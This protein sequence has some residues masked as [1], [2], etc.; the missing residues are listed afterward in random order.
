MLKN[1]LSTLAISLVLAFT[2]LSV[3]FSFSQAI[4]AGILQDY[5]S[6]GTMLILAGS[7]IIIIIISIFSDIPIAVARPQ[8]EPFPLIIL[9]V[10]GLI[11][12]YSSG[13][14][15]FLTVLI[16]IAMV[17][18]LTGLVLYVVG[19]FK[20]GGRVRFVPF[21]V[22]AGFLA[23][24]GV[25]LIINGIT[26]VIPDNL[27]FKNISILWTIPVLLLWLPSVLY[28]IVLFFVSERSKNA[29]LFPGLIF[30]GFIL[31][32][33]IFFLSSQSF[34]VLKSSH[35]L[36]NIEPISFETTF[37]FHHEVNWSYV[38]HNLGYMVIIA[39]ISVFALLFILISL[40]LILKYDV[41]FNKELKVAG[42][43]NIL[44]GCVG[45]VVGYHGLANTVLISKS[46]S[47]TRFIG[48]FCGIVCLGAIYFAAITLAYFPRFILSGLIVFLGLSLFH[49]WTFRIWHQFD[50]FDKGVICAV[51]FTSVFLGFFQGIIAGFS[52]S[53]IVFILTYSKISPL[54][55][56][57]YG[58]QLTSIYQRPPVP[59]TI[60]K[61][62][63]EEIIYIKLQNYL[64][65]G[66]VYN[67]VTQI[68]L[69]VKSERR[70]PINYVIYD[71]ER[72]MGIDSSIELAFRKINK[73]AEKYNFCLVISG[74]ASHK[75]IDLQKRVTNIPLSKFLKIIPRIE[76][77]IDF[78][79]L[80]LLK[81]EK[82]DM[83]E[84]LSEIISLEDYLG[85][86]KLADLIPIYFKQ[87]E[88]K[89]GEHLLYKNDLS[90]EL[91]YLE[92]GQ[93]KIYVELNNGEK[94][95]FSVIGPGNFIGEIA[96]YLHSPRSASIY[97]ETQC[98]LKSIDQASLKKLN[99]ENPEFYEIFNETIIFILAVKLRD[100]NRKLEMLSL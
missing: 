35:L 95:V 79:E 28:G 69:L 86:K 32:Y 39:F 70:Y 60:L 73:Y 14:E 72:V 58:N 92:S 100:T 84:H 87:V 16:S 81:K 23:S 83:Q 56:V 76:D 59:T 90:N 57:I 64:F 38:F 10:H 93:L 89:K 22:I 75:N 96:F 27:T 98:S 21:P 19:Y 53:I 54:R 68:Q 24:A 45:G 61:N 5:L 55:Y 43:A 42:L 65:F 41:D 47:N 1:A 31:F 33:L 49:S 30:G 50:K 7:G 37:N 15:A 97:A 18:F 46:P 63:G 4:Y 12:H 82:Y 67:L 36:L 13:Q 52:I 91:F 2:I 8:D 88:L 11:L 17:T 3:C 29:L 51:I 34:D 77:A 66:S 26:Q 80:Q 9:L 62:K 40:D 20:L 78:C 85:H 71:M 48:I 74:I 94:K 99:R 6:I 44:G 25:L